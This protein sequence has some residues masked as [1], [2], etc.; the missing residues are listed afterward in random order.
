[1]SSEKLCIES[2]DDLRTFVAE[3][4]C[5]RERL[6]PGAFPLFER[7]LHR[8][9]QPCGIH[10]CLAAPKS[11]R[12]TAVWEIERRDVRFYDS[13]GERFQQVELVGELPAPSKRQAA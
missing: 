10:F 2:L 3:T 6:A 9:G 12:L 7:I 4:L 11:V 1:M 5:Y 8:D 13:K